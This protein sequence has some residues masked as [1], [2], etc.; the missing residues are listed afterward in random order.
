MRSPGDRTAVEKAD[1]KSKRKGGY[2]QFL[3]KLKARFERRKAK[4]NPNNPASYGKY[5]GW[6]L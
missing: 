4:K 6:E 1:G 2:H 3:K 5:R